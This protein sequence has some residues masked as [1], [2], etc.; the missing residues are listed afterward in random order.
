MMAQPTSSTSTSKK[1]AIV[2]G[3]NAGIGKEITAGLMHTGAHVV[4]GCR[5]MEACEVARAELQ[6]RDL[7]GTCECC[8]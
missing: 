2:T 7:P 6:K 4:M 1:Y 8:R 5:N 3:A